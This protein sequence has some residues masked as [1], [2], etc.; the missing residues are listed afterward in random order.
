MPSLTEFV[1]S[2]LFLPWQIKM[3]T[4]KKVCLACEWS[5]INAQLWLNSITSWCEFNHR[6][7]P[8]L[9][10]N[11]QHLN[12]ILLISLTKLSV[13]RR[14]N[15]LKSVAFSSCCTRVVGL[16]CGHQRAH[17]FTQKV[18]IL[19]PQIVCHFQKSLIHHVNNSW[20]KCGIISV[21]KF[22]YMCYVEL[23][24]LNCTFPSVSSLQTRVD[25]ADHA[26]HYASCVGEDELQLVGPRALPLDPHRPS[27][28][29][30]QGFQLST[31]CLWAVFGCFVFLPSVLG[32]VKEYIGRII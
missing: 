3:S 30:W 20:T 28:I 21:Y 27:H 12:A 2:V 4:V 10:T 26:E 9:S 6:I 29:P 8:V 17:Y 23:V 32:S 5:M 14:P 13:L 25:H 11:W 24:L 1:L 18:S 31:P 22:Q 19:W 15:A 7:F 16:Q